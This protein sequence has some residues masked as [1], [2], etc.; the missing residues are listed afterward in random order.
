MDE[1][2]TR[3]S[4]G[5]NDAKKSLK[6]KSVSGGEWVAQ[7]NMLKCGRRGDAMIIRVVEIPNTV[8]YHEVLST[9]NAKKFQT[10]REMVKYSELT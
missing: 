2:N 8:Y 6:F 10:E 9:L 1:W 4:N 5:M 3:E 7:N